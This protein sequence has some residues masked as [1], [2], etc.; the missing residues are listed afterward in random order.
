MKVGLIITTYNWTEA[1]A[2]VLHSI[3]FQSYFPSEVVVCDDGSEIE[4]RNLIIGLQKNFPCILKHVWQEDK[5]FRAA[6][7]RN[8]GI[9]A[10]SKDIEYIVSIDGDMIL[11]KNFIKDHVNFSERN[12]FIQGGRALISEKLTAKLLEQ[13]NTSHN[14]Y[15]FSQGI[16]NRKNTLYIPFFTKFYKK[17]NQDLRGVKACNMSFWRE[18]LFLINGFNEDFIGW[19]REDTEIAVRLFKNG[20]FRKNIKFSGL[21]FHLYHHE[22]SRSNISVNDHLLSDA[23]ISNSHWCDNGLVKLNEN[24]N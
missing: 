18:D 16:S 3:R 17:L 22:N 9:L 7:I 1:L 23:I 4:C 13:V 21:A 10:L 11:H 6:S 8:K 15:L 19:G 12:C 24:E 20:K 5:G 14:F 2:K